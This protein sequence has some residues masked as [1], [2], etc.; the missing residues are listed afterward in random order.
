MENS[1]IVFNFHHEFI[2]NN[3]TRVT[4]EMLFHLLPEMSE[5]CWSAVVM[6]R[7][8]RNPMVNIT[9]HVPHRS[10]WG[11]ATNHRVNSNNMSNLFREVDFR[12][13]YAF[14]GQAFYVVNDIPMGIS[15][16]VDVVPG[17][18][19]AP[20]SNIFR[21]YTLPQRQPYPLRLPTTDN[22]SMLVQLPALIQQTV[23]INHLASLFQDENANPTPLENINQNVDHPASPDQQPKEDE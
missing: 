5:W 15:N 1:H 4:V 21:Y 10:F 16:Q 7:D 22:Q 3:H 14:N 18:N 2:Y 23:E 9:L 17:Q 20:N 13:D 19:G 6:I 8:H 11:Q 12:F